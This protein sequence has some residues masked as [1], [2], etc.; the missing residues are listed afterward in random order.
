[1]IRATRCQQGYTQERFAAHAGIDR[2]YYGAIER[3]KFNLTVHTLLRISAGLNVSPAELLAHSLDDKPS[4]VV[5][6]TAAE[7][8]DGDA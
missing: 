6:R 7:V 3:G 8:K 2:G 4:P 1:V 5:N